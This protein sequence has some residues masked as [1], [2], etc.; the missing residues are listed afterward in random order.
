M[1][2][3]VVTWEG[4]PTRPAVSLTV[5]PEGWTGCR[6]AEG[7]DSPGTEGHP[8]PD[9]RKGLSSPRVWG[10]CASNKTSCRSL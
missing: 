9:C 4:I 7:L 6:G 8:I 5:P 3:T 10:D 1:K 2:D